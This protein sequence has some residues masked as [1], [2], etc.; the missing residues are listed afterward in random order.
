MVHSC[1]LFVCIFA[2]TVAIAPA[3]NASKP[4]KIAIRAASMIDGKSDK[5]IANAVILIEGDKISAVGSGLAI[6]PDAKVIDLKNLTLMPGLIDVHTHLLL[7]MDGA[8]VTLQDVEMLKAVATLSTAER[9][10]LGAKL[11]REDLEAG[12]TTV[13]DLGNS[14]VNGDVA[15]AE[16]IDNGWIPGPRI[17]PATRALA[18]PGG[19]FGRLIPEVQHVIEQEYVTLNGA[20]SARQAVRQALYNGARCIKVIVNGS[21]ANV[22]LDEMKAIVDE[23]HK[24]DV[25]VAAHA[26]GDKA[27][28]IAA[29]AGADSIEHA[30]IIADDTLKMMA[31]KQIFLVPTDGTVDEYLRMSLGN[32]TPT[33][34]E[35]KKQEEMFKPYVTGNRD[36]L[37]R[38]L[39]M[40]VPIAMGSDMYLTMPNETRGQASL[41]VIDAYVEEGMT[42]VQIIHAATSNAAELLGWQAQ[43]GTLEAGKYADIIAVAGD[44]LKDVTTLKHAQF[45]MKGGTV[46]KQ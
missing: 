45:V 42:P 25:K 1:R 37:Q 23:A 15:L 9:A 17:V 39:K 40:N 13:R 32:R 28:R 44:P 29:E 16:A 43:V 46:V 7:E 41:D 4:P 14:G 18:A 6:P 2:F 22:T 24:A 8:D 3:Q 10:L 20:D 27:T 31:Q 38:A 35:R 33:T 30:Y 12:I 36:R 21:P 5:T 11:G 26:I 19:Q 34:E